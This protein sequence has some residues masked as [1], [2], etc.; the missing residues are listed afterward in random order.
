ML[1]LVYLTKA[2]NLSNL[3][4]DLDVVAAKRRLASQIAGLSVGWKRIVCYLSQ[5][6]R[7]HAG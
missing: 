5:L 7:C 6:P 1:D 4:Q 2:P 3:L